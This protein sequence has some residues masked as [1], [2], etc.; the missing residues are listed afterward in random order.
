M[1]NENPLR[2]GRVTH[3]FVKGAGTQL[4]SRGDPLEPLIGQCF[5]PQSKRQPVGTDRRGIEI[6]Y[7][8]G[9]EV[10]LYP[11]GSFQLRLGE[12]RKGF[13]GAPDLDSD[14]GAYNDENENT[15]WQK[16][17]RLQSVSPTLCHARREQRAEDREWK[18]ENVKGL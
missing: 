17:V 2:P 10:L 3:P 13:R 16:A 15:G 7:L 1:A 5:P 11:Q 9:V 4:G 18:D 6:T 8:V 12:R 14:K